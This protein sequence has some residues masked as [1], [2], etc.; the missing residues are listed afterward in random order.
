MK[1]FTPILKTL[2]ILIPFTALSHQMQAQCDENIT[3]LFFENLET[4]DS[5]I[6]KNYFKHNNV[7]KSIELHEELDS[8][9]L[10]IG[11]DTSIIESARL[12]H[13]E[14]QIERRDQYASIY[15]SNSQ[16]A[17]ALL[18]LE[19]EN[20]N[21]SFNQL[22]NCSVFLIQSIHNINKLQ[23][24]IRSL[25]R[26]D[27]YDSHKTLIIKTK[28]KEQLNT[29]MKVIANQDYAWYNFQTDKR[30]FVKGISLFSGNDLFRVVSLVTTMT[31]L[32]RA[33]NKNFLQANND[34]DYT[35]NI[36]FEV[37]TDFL[38]VGR[39]RNLKT[40][41]KLFWGFDTYTPYF[42]DTSIF[43]SDTSFNVNDRPHASFQYFGYGI[44]GLSWNG[45]FRWDIDF[46]F[47]KIGGHSASGFQTVLHQDVS[48]SPRP[49]GW[50]AQ[51]ANNG[52][53][54]FSFH[55]KPEW[56]IRKLS[57]HKQTGLNG[58]GVFISIPA[59]IEVG[60]YMTYAG[61]GLRIS[62]KN[63]ND[64][65]SNNV[66]S[67]SSKQTTPWMFS[68][69]L[70]TRYVVHNT[71]LTGYGIFA[72]NEDKNDAFTPPSIYTLDKSDT[73]SVL[74]FGDFI[75]SRTFKSVMFFYKWSIRSPEITKGV[76]NPINPE[77]GVDYTGRWHQW[78][79]IGV[80]FFM[81]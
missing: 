46:K 50:G 27:S 14:K 79:T 56:I 2:L 57:T 19:I 5:L 15:E 65:N 78:G 63:L 32:E 10:T 23:D 76:T 6:D 51:I 18:K 34:M 77:L 72:S 67:R 1:T 30:Q 55:Y 24:I 70:K 13:L 9:L 52:R 68:F 40:Y 75:M 45:L 29:Q 62:N 66:I 47:G 17:E 58:K 37:A 44:S 16:I 42:K 3:D 60:N 31:N 80:S 54:G 28:L 38:K 64:V 12:R 7:Q 48:Y 8:T 33:K 73:K 20:P 59:E 81:P 21:Y 71:M 69:S 41:Q 36:Q 35:G 39:K 26:N 74:V 49:V 25:E 61:A 22:S 11:S 53:L 4:S 43:V